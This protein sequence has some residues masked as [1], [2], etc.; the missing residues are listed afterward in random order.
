M[1]VS[2]EQLGKQAKQAARQLATLGRTQKQALLLQLASALE[3]QSALILQANRE[4][5]EL[6]QDLSAA[7]IDRLT[8][9]PERIS[10]MA[11][12]VRHVAQLHDYVGEIID[13]G[14][15]DSG[16][17]IR[18]ER[19]PL[20]VVGVIYES[21]PNVTIDV[22][23]LCLKTGNSVI[24]RGGKETAHTN[25]TLLGVIQSALAAAGIDLNAVQMLGDFS[26]ETMREMVQLDRFIDVIIPRGG[27]ALQDFCRQNAT[28]PVMIGGIGVCHIFVEESALVS[29][30]LA[31]IKNAKTQRPST[32]N[33]VETLLV[34]KSIA[35][36]FLPKLAKYLGEEVTL[37]ADKKALKYFDSKK[38]RIRLLQEE[39]LNREWLSYDL[40]IVVVKNL[41]AALEH[42]AQYGT[43]HSEAILTQNPQLAQ[44]FVQQ[45]D[46]AAVYINASTR[47]TDGAQFGL[48]AEVAVSTQKLHAR[49]PMGLESLTTYKW[50]V[51]GDYLTR[52]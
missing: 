39:R 20:G 47:F 30:S 15:L 16:L 19:V 43:G 52:A 17:R 12:E 33:T 10:S 46:A 32:C 31:L 50:I 7:M 42:I 44:Q 21:R 28:V 24:L 51:E 36:T 37:H 27:Q 1:S 41:E 11:A 4:D 48:G 18:R 34:Q 40:N 35:K 6:A 23:S 22:A 29:K 49:G 14:R 2:V 3:E 13:G 8:L 45:V 9:T 5:I 26:R 38:G 25:Q